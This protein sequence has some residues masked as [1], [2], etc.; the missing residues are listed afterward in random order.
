VENIKTSM[1]ALNVKTG[2]QDAGLSMDRITAAAEAARNLEFVTNSPWIVAEEDLFEI[3]K[4]I[5]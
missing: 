1:A 4:Q 5:I 3:L 2:L